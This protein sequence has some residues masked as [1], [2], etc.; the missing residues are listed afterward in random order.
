MGN[1]KNQVIKKFKNNRFNSRGHLLIDLDFPESERERMLAKDDL[2]G[3]AEYVYYMIQEMEAWFLSQPAIL[4][5]YYK[6]NISSRI[7]ERNPADIENP[8]MFLE[9]LT[10]NTIKGKYHK[11][12]HGTALLELLDAN[13]LIDTF[14]DF[15]NLIAEMSA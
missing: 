7:P 10:R 11:V 2:G 13:E 15:K 5:Q 6:Q 14:S 1:G 12:K 3:F 4:D 9:D 8:S